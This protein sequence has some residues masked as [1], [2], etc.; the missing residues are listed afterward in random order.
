MW[1]A[2]SDVVWRK[3]QETL[4]LLNTSSG[5]YYTINPTGAMLWISLVEKQGS[6]D[7]AVK[8]IQQQC[9]GAP[10]T[11]AIRNDC[12]KLLEEWKA[13]NLIEEKAG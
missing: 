12:T 1:C 8:A 2:K 4:V 5:L 11:A 13:E 10:D 6:F 3:S 7:E 9:A